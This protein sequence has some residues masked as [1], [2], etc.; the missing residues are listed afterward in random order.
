MKFSLSLLGV[1]LTPLCVYS[2][3]CSHK[4]SFKIE[5]DVVVDERE[6]TFI[7]KNSGIDNFCLQPDA[8]AYFYMNQAGLAD[9]IAFPSGN[10][11]YREISAGDEVKYSYRLSDS[12][13]LGGD[14]EY[15]IYINVYDCKVRELDHVTFKNL[16]ENHP[17]YYF[18][19]NFQRSGKLH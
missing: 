15:S 5:H 3:A 13:I 9:S 6:V 12:I 18:L 8:H 10:D 17:S 7:I 19:E 2:T 4:Q 1:L 16:E 11:G 14:A